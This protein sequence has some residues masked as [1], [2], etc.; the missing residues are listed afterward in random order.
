M[1]IDARK[2]KKRSEIKLYYFYYYWIPDRS[3]YIIMVL[4]GS[5]DHVSNSPPTA[6]DKSALR[7]SVLWFDCAITTPVLVSSGASL[8]QR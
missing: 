8:L 6:S 5:L 1:T 4:L 3:H 7:A 2:K